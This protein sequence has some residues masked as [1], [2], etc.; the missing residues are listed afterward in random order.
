MEHQHQLFNKTPLCVLFN[1][2]L[3]CQTFQ[4]FY[5]HSE[6]RKCFVPQWVIGVNCEADSVAQ[7]PATAS[8]ENTSHTRLQVEV[9][10]SSASWPSVDVDDVDLET[11]SSGS[12][13]TC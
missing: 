11:M 5:S 6:I 2:Q 10:D 7:I 9:A 12:G 3:R 1:K 4:G 8:G 13:K